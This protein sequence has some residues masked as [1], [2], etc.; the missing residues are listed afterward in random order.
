[1]RKPVVLFEHLQTTVEHRIPERRLLQCCIG[2]RWR[3]SPDVELLVWD[4][5]RKQSIK[6][7]A[8]DESM[9]WKLSSLPWNRYS[10]ALSTRP[11]RRMGNGVEKS[12]PLSVC[13]SKSR[14]CIGLYPGT[15]KDDGTL[16]L[17]VGTNTHSVFQICKYLGNGREPPSEHWSFLVQEP[18]EPDRFPIPTVELDD[19]YETDTPIIPLAVSNVT[20]RCFSVTGI[21]EACDFLSFPQTPILVKPEMTA[22]I[23]VKMNPAEVDGDFFETIWLCTDSPEYPTIPVS[24]VG[25]VSHYWDVKPDK[26]QIHFNTHDPFEFELTP[27]DG[28]LPIIRH[29]VLGPQGG[30]LAITEVPDGTLRVCFLPPKGLPKAPHEWTIHLMSLLTNATPITLH[31]CVL[32]PLV[33]QNELQYISLVREDKDVV[34]RINVQG[35]IPAPVFPDNG[36]AIALYPREK[37]IV[38]FGGVSDEGFPEICL[39]ISKAAI[40]NWDEKRLLYAYLPRFGTFALSVSVK[41]QNN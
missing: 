37:G 34:E 33:D 36:E 16:I 32:P 6:F 22:H 25:T 23:T 13:I 30:S 2:E 29:Q 39:S 41:E 10:L 14:E 21:V 5:S 1:M 7:R 27:N 38:S 18:Q 31:A 28:A 9:Q 17:D 12:I 35:I 3:V 20:G 8:Q 26:R 24:F 4:K 15:I 19:V 11:L 40:R